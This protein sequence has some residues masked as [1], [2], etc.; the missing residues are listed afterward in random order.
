MNKIGP[1]PNSIYPNENIKQVCYIKNVIKN[2]NIQVGDY[3]YYDDVNG[4]EE[5]EK[6]VTHH[7]DFLGDKLIIGKF[8]A[9][10][11]GIEFV[12]NGANH[13]M[14]SVTTYPFYIMGNG[15]EKTTP[16]FDDLPI[17]VKGDT[18]IGNDVWIGQNVVVMPGIHI[19]NGAIIAANSVVTKNVPDYHIVGGNP[20]KI[21]RKRFDDNLIQYLLALKWWNWSAEK[22]F[23]NLE[24][25]CSSDIEKIKNIE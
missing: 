4:A 7:Y 21:I 14:C 13:Q 8:C 12:M 25:L 24:I 15:W 3:T 2:P 11:H 20:A 17:K 22:I 6:H 16:I 23:N 1:N 9:I 5:F 19:G 10:A 18:I